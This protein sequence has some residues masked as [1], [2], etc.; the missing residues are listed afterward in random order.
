[1]YKLGN[2]TDNR[3]AYLNRAQ[4][5]PPWPPPITTTTPD[6]VSQSI[7]EIDILHIRL[8]RKIPRRFVISLS[9]GFHKVVPPLVLADVVQPEEEAHG[10]SRAEADDTREHARAVRRRLG[11][12]TIGCQLK[13][14]KTPKAG[15]T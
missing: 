6:I 14:L 3:D 8:I 7:P 15:L 13:Y 11:G 10:Y 12:S 5:H 4:E 2:I 1:M 9:P